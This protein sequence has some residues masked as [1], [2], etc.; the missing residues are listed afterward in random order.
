M[1]CIHSSIVGSV[2][3]TT[4]WRWRTTLSMIRRRRGSGQPS[5]RASTASVA[6][7]SLKSSIRISF[8]TRSSSTAIPWPTPMHMVQSA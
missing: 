5:I 4:A 3:R 2:S 6:F 8:H 7:S 1:A